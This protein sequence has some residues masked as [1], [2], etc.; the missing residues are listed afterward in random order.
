[1]RDSIKDLAYFNDLIRYKKNFLHN[2]YKAMNDN[3]IDFKKRIG[4]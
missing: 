4:F 2:Y 3:S 1:M